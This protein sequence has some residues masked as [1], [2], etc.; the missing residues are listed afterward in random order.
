VPR[1]ASE[2]HLI[3]GSYEEDNTDD[4]LPEKPKIMTTMVMMNMMKAYLEF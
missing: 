4:W 3:N 1:I 2:K